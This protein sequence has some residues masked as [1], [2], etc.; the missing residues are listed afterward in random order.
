VE[1]ARRDRARA[2][3]HF[4]RVVQTGGNLYLCLD[5]EQMNN[6]AADDG[7]LETVESLFLGRG[8]FGIP[9]GESFFDG[10]LSDVRMYKGALP[11]E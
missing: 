8:K 5:G 7:H 1:L 10:F 4:V 6:V 9:A 3:W 11:C 2:D